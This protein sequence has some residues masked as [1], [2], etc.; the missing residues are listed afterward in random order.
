MTEE[1]KEFESK[2]H[3]KYVVPKYEGIPYTK[4]LITSALYHWDDDKTSIVALYPPDEDLKKGVVPITFYVN[5]TELQQLFG[6]LEIVGELSK[7]ERAEWQKMFDDALL[8]R[9]K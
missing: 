4:Y 7:E 8:K 9:M 6:A 2:Y 1:Q 3:L 5:D